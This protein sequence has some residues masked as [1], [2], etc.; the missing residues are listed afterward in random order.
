MAKS[1]Y[2]DL[3]EFLSYDDSENKELRKVESL[4]DLADIATVNTRKLRNLQQIQQR[5]RA[6]L[7]QGPDP[8]TKQNLTNLLTQ[9]ETGVR[10][11]SLRSAELIRRRTDLQ[12]RD[13]DDRRLKLEEILRPT[14]GAMNNERRS[15]VSRSID[16]AEQLKLA[17]IQANRNNQRSLGAR[18]YLWEQKFLLISSILDQLPPLPSDLE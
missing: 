4:S 1:S 18:L 2:P 7:D 12:K 15:F 5:L 14:K 16:F 17:R 3:N 13:M 10:E 9:T 8:Q 11:R 6:D